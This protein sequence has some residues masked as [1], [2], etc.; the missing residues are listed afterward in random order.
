MAQPAELPGSVT[1]Q[2]EGPETRQIKELNELAK[3]LEGDLIT[4]DEFQ[5][6]KEN[7]LNS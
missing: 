2:L 4:A 1:R 6:L 7:I 3:L 5:R